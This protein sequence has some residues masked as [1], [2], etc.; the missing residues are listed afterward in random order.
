[1]VTT[2]GSAERHSLP[3][4]DGTIELN[5]RRSNIPVL[6]LCDFAR[7]NNPNRAVLVVS[8]V[9][10]R[11]IPVRPR[12]SRRAFSMMAGKI[13]KDLPGPVVFIGLAESAIGIGNGVYEAYERQTWRDDLMFIHSS[14]HRLECQVALHFHEEHS[15][16]TQ[17]YLYFPQDQ[18]HAALF[19]QARSVVLVEDEVTTGRTLQNLSRSLT[20]IMPKL[21]H[22]VVSV[23]T[24]WRSEEHA[25]S[26]PAG[27]PTASTVVSLL[28]GDLQFVPGAS[29]VT[30]M[31][32]LNGNGLPKDAYCSTAYGRRGLRETKLH[33]SV[34][35]KAFAAA[36]GR[37]LV[38]A[39]EEFAFPPFLV[40]EALEKVGCDVVYQSTTRTPVLPGCCMSSTM[41]FNDNYG[42]G[43][44]NFLYNV[45]PGVYDSV[46]LCHETPTESLDQE[47]VR[48]LN[49]TTIRI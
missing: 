42:D 23:L 24:D 20:Q 45:Q 5:V 6:D 7:R 37:C 43:I 18:G 44:P 35:E 8:K 22:I 26:F 10:G 31:P 38:L 27:M 47:L 21:E 13:P 15:H 46:I 30:T 12:V 40:A 1:M 2:N 11:H 36:R 3:L 33:S 4:G 25:A 49:A 17:E 41:T 9:A 34:L 14:R 48:S 32:K 16:A 39:S 19:A 29:K 28:E